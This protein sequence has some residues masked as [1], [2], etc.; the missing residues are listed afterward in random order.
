MKRDFTILWGALLIVA[1]L[2]FLIQAITTGGT[3]STDRVWAG[4]WALIFA[5]AGLT[6]GWVFLTDTIGSWWAAIPAMALIALGILTG[7][8]SFGWAQESDWLG[9][10]FLGMIGLSF[11]I[12]YA[13]KREFWWAIIPGGALLSLAAVVLASIWSTGEVAGSVLFFGLAITFAILWAVPT[14]EGHM[15]WAL[16]PAVIL[17]FLGTAVLLN[18]G[19]AANYV[20]AI[21]LIA[22]GLWL[23]YRQFGGG[24]TM[25]HR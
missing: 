20:W 10:L 21:G 6:F 4:I 11:W 15:G 2:L 24:A 16:F 23:L 13:V 18:F 25:Q 22:I 19:S 9:A 1:G 17:A 14:E 12:I 7:A 5:G 8:A 3:F